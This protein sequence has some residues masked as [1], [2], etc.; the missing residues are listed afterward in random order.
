[1]IGKYILVGAI[2]ATL[3]A[4]ASAMADDSNNAV[5]GAVI[6]AGVGGVVGHAVA[7]R[8]GAWVGGAV[9]AVTGAAI[10]NN[11]RGH[12]DYDRYGRRD[13]YVRD[14]AYYPASYYPAPQYYAP[15]T[16]YYGQTPYAVRTAPVYQRYADHG[17]HEWRDNDHNSW[18]YD[19]DD[20]GRRGYE[21]RD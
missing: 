10:A 7:G 1:M 12:D 21:H 18:R 19:R 5:L 16:Q 3:G 17:G 8:N 11:A 13:V 9:R 15:E 20:R 2:A 14:S 6:G 4:S